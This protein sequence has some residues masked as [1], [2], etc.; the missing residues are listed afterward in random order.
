MYTAYC[1]AIISVSWF[2]RKIT[3]GQRAAD[4][5]TPA[6]LGGSASWRCLE[7][8]CTCS[9]I[10]PSPGPGRCTADECRRRPIPSPLGTTSSP[11]PTATCNLQVPWRK[12]REVLRDEH[13]PDLWFRAV[14]HRTNPDGHADAGRAW[15]PNDPVWTFEKNGV[16][17]IRSTEYPVP[18]ATRRSRRTCRQG[19]R[20]T[21]GRQPRRRERPMSTFTDT[22]LQRA[23]STPSNQTLIADAGS[24]R[25]TSSSGWSTTASR[26]SRECCCST[27]SSRRTCPSPSATSRC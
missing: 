14:P 11:G 17:S 24:P 1:L 13:R 27:R 19:R 22:P 26:R 5:V 7:C 6:V 10:T 25:S 12:A 15:P 2:A 16:Y 21:P 3:R 9:R 20:M 8:P 4:D 18:P 23:T